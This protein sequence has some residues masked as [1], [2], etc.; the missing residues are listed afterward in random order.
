M[1]PRRIEALAREPTFTHRQPVVKDNASGGSA[2]GY[3]A[4]SP[5]SGG[6]WTSMFARGGSTGVAVSSYTSLG[7]STAWACVKRLSEDDGKL[8]RRVMRR[9]PNG[10]VRPDYKHPLNKL[11]R[12]PNPWQT[13]SQFW[14]YSTAWYALR[15]NAYIAIIRDEESGD[16]VMLVPIAPDRCQI[17]I[18]PKNGLLY[19]NISHPLFGDGRDVLISR[20]NVIH[21]RNSISFDGYTGI[22]PIAA[23]QDVFGLGIAAQQHGAVVFRQGTNMAGVLK[24]PGK[25]N[26]EGRQF[27][28]QELMDA[29]SGVQNMQKP[30]VLDEGM[31]FEP[32]SMT[33]EDAQLLQT[34][35][36]SVLEICRMF[37][38]PP[39]KVQDFSRAHFANMEQGNL[40]YASDALQP[41]GTQYEEECQRTLFFENE[42]DDYYIEVD[43]DTLLRAD[44]KT[45]Y[46]TDEIGIRSGRL[47]QNEARISDG[48]EP[49]VPNGDDFQ[50]PLNIGTTG[51]KPDSTITS[52]EK[53][54][55]SDGDGS[56]DK[57]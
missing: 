16:P 48:R 4:V 44:R 38:V 53:P 54:E 7:V 13:A 17:K 51:D 57:D 23:G 45:R 10:G 9:L 35:Q 21:I 56:S 3:T 5:G 6:L 30:M 14:S 37:G 36:F 33:N 22:S 40:Q 32:T 49:N 29:H 27:L 42:Q 46:E 15:G 2:G 34:R 18:A 11:L 47:T 12:A 1:P 41:I 20:D 52:D 31:T 24:H 19:Y 43:Y 39:H 50:K 8:P 28:R 25:L 26:A 55:P